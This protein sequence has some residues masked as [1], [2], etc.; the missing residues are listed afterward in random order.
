MQLLKNNPNITIE[1]SAHTD[2]VG[3][4]RYNLKLSK[5]RARVSTSYLV[6]KG[7][8]SKRI[9]SKGYGERKPVATNKTAVGRKLNRRVEIKVIKNN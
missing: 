7:V 6:S 5:A 2:K 9:Q 1:L 8:S 3:S 4:D